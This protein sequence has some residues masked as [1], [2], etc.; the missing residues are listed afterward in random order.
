MASYS[1]ALLSYAL[2]YRKEPIDVLSYQEIFEVDVSS[3]EI[4]GK[5]TEYSSLREL[6]NYPFPPEI[7]EKYPKYSTG[8]IAHIFVTLSSTDLL[9]AMLG[10]GGCLAAFIY[11]MYIL[12]TTGIILLGLSAL[13]TILSMVL[14]IVGLWWEKRGGK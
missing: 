6:P 11:G 4:E 13:F 8:V 12:P 3:M 2:S 1:N 10:I 7:P 14:P 9:F 5:E